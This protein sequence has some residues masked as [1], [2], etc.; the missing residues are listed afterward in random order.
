MQT[1]TTSTERDAAI[2]Q[3][4]INGDT[5]AQIA[6]RHQL[7]RERIRQIL[8]KSGVTRRSMSETID[9]RNQRLVSEHRDAI[10]SVF[11]Q[12]RSIQGTLA[13]FK[14]TVSPSVVRAVLNEVPANERRRLSHKRRTHSDESMQ[15]ALRDAS[16]A[17]ANTVHAYTEWRNNHP[18]PTSVPSVPLLI[19]RYGSW[20]NA[21]TTAGL[22]TSVAGAPPKLFTEADIA[23]SIRRFLNACAFSGNAPSARN[24]DQWAKTVRNVPLLSTVRARTNKT[25]TEILDHF[26]GVS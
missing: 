6:E 17:G 10:L 8:A 11:Q 7:T 25:W 20:R 18:N 24:Y 16:A 21:R 13:H 22:T 12:R 2:Q 3:A 4:Y 26:G 19:M 1:E 15:G 9:R 5:L 23:D 14:G